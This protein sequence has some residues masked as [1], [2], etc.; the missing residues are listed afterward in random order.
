[1][2]VAIVG[3]LPELKILVNKRHTMKEIIISLLF[4]V[5]IT[6]ATTSDDAVQARVSQFNAEWADLQPADSSYGI[7]Q[8]LRL[9]DLNSTGLESVKAAAERSDYS[10]AEQL[11]L[12]YF[13]STRQP[14]PLKALRSTPPKRVRRPSRSPV[15]SRPVKFS[16]LSAPRD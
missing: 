16:P 2:T 1:M 11:L 12:E 8:I 15:S 6:F 10:A 3:K 14:K 9:F 7:E 13:K 5:N 4:V